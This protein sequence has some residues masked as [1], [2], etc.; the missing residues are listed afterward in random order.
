[1]CLVLPHKCQSLEREREKRWSFASTVKNEN[2]YG[3]STTA[4]KMDLFLKAITCGLASPNTHSM[5]MALSFCVVCS[6]VISHKIYWAINSTI[7]T[8]FFFEAK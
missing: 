8:W 1:M 6:R 2:R 3:S 4:T 5:V 7:Y